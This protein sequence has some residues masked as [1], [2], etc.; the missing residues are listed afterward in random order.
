[1]KIIEDKNFLSKNSI[2]FIENHIFATNFPFY[3]Y[4]RTTTID[5]DKNHWMGHVIIKRPEERSETDPLYN[6]DYAENFINIFEDFV[7]KNKINCEEL[8]RCCVNLTFNTIA[9]GCPTHVDHPYPHKQLIVYL[10]DCDKES[11]TVLLDKSEKKKIAQITPEKYKGV[12]F[13]S[14]PHYMKFPKKDI[15]LAIIYTFR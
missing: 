3:L 4:H 6:S 10:N 9:E 15:R 5:G 7:K 12:C 14:G 13:D 1:M 2:Y 11:V 8:L